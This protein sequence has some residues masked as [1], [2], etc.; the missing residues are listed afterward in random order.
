MAFPE[1]LESARLAEVAE[2]AATRQDIAEPR[3]P[4]RLPFLGQNLE[5]PAILELLAVL[6]DPGPQRLPIGLPAPVVAQQ[7][8]V[9]EIDRRV[10]VRFV[11]DHHQAWHSLGPA[12]RG[13][14]AQAGQ[15]LQHHLGL[16]AAACGGE[17][18]LAGDGAARILAAMAGLDQGEQ[19]VL[20]PFSAILAEA[21]EQQIGAAGERAA[22]AAELA[23]D[24]GAQHVAVA[25][26]P[27]QAEQVADQGQ[28]TRLGAR[29]GHDVVG[30]RRFAPVQAG[31]ARRG[32]HHVLEAGFAD[33]K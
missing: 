13:R 16:A 30:E 12:R 25:L 2:L 4:A 7:R 3:A 15:P 20:R 17:R 19:E 29:L 23:I 1:A 27:Q 28:G 26:V 5:Q 10:V 22:E 33:R 6:I 24:L 32:P 9:G 11:A 18:H 21:L 8:L 31:K 14:V